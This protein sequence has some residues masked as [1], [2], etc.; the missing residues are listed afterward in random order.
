MF[1]HALPDY[2]YLRGIV[3][4]D[5]MPNA[6]DFAARMLTLGNSAWQTREETAQILQVLARAALKAWM[7]CTHAFTMHIPERFPARK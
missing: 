5:D 6:R 2:A 3:P 4:Q 7:D 1:I